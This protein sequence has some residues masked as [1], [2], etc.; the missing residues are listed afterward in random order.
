KFG[1]SDERVQHLRGNNYL[2]W[3]AIRWLAKEGLS[4]LDLG[5]TAIG[6]EGLR[7]FKLSMG[8]SESLLEYWKYD[9]RK[10][11]FVEDRDEASGWYAPLLSLLPV[12]V[13]RGI[14]KLMYRH[15]A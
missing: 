13:L 15:L 7:R 9:L 11:E 2:M 6:N 14:G 3:E 5:R 12:S 10:S 1:A 4:E 8:A